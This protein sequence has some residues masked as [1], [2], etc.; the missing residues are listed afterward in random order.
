MASGFTFLVE[1]FIE[2]FVDLCAVGRNGRDPMPFTQ[3][4]SGITFCKL[5][6]NTTT[7]IL[8]QYSFSD[9]PRFTCTQ[10]CFSGLPF[11]FT[12]GTSHGTV[13]ISAQIR[14]KMCTDL[15]NKPFYLFEVGVNTT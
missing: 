8:R 2:M 11:N 7:R 14:V 6:Y 15:K 9:I 13:A 5:W 12:C 1:N 4:L 10:V 3:F